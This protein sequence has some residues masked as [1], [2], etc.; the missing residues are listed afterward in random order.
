MAGEEVLLKRELRRHLT[1]TYDQCVEIA[2]RHNVTARSVIAQAVRE[3]VTYIPSNSKKPSKKKL[4]EL[5]AARD[6]AKELESRTLRAKIASDGQ[7]FTTGIF[8]PMA[9]PILMFIL[10]IAGCFAVLKG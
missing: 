8:H 5:Q 1:L 2:V 4:A 7:P 3:N 10:M 9:F 6:D